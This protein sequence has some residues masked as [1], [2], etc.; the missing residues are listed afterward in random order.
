[1]N[2]IF[3]VKLLPIRVNYYTYT[4]FCTLS[5]LQLKQ[6]KVF[7]K[8]FAFLLLLRNLLFVELLI[9]KILKC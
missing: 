4:T 5:S 2:A 1:M 3:I 8:I 6:L 9:G 7:K